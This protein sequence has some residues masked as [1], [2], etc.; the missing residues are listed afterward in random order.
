[1][2]EGQDDEKELSLREELEAAFEASA[3]PADEPGDEPG[4]EPA[5]EPAKEAPPADDKPPQDKA[6]EPADKAAKEPAD[7]PAGDKPK[8]SFRDPPS[9]WSKEAKELWAKTFSALD[10][11]NPTHKQIGAIRDMIFE[12]NAEMEADY[13]RKTQELAQQRQ[14]VDGV[15]KLLEP[16]KTAIEAIGSTVERELGNLLQLNDF[17]AQRPVEFL[18]WFA[19]ERNLDKGAIAQALGISANTP[20][21]G[22]QPGVSAPDADDPLGLIPQHYKDAVKAIPQLQ[23]QIENLTQQVGKVGQEWGGFRQSQHTQQLDGARQHLQNWINEKDESGNPKRPFYA[24]AQPRMMAMLEK[25]VA[26]NLDEAYA[27]ACAADP[28]IQQRIRETE[29]S[30]RIAEQER[31]AKESWSRKSAAASGISGAP[32]GNSPPPPSGGSGDSIRALIEA[33][34]DASSGSS[35]I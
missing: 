35:H 16:R 4:K 14:Q 9:R 3:K 28:T 21:P 26:T 27:M 2:P 25:G 34:W 8:V 22:Q 17:A 11:K 15:M 18:Q 12:R 5:K 20:A 6:K 23:Q 19:R 7:K 33:A 29:D 31:R 10:E 32:A 1:M 13:T 30:R 24:E